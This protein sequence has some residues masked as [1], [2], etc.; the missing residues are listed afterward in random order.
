[1]IQTLHQAHEEIKSY[2]DKKNYALAQD[3]LGQCQECAISIGTLIEKL[4][5]EG[6]ITVSYVEAYCDVVFSAYEELN[7]KDVNTNK[8]Y[9]N[10]KKQLLRIENSLKNDVPVRKEIAFFPYKASMWDALESVYLA[11]K[12][13]PDCDAYCVPIPYYDRNPDRS[14]GQMHYEGREYPKNIEV[15]DWQTYNFEERKP[16]VVYIHNPYDDWNLVTCVHPRF[17]SANL[18]K[19][20]EELVYI[21]YFVLSEIEPDDQAGIDGMKHFCFLPGVVNA[22]KVILQSEKMKQIYVNEYLKAAQAHGL[23]GY[24]LDRKKLE[25]KFLGLGSPK[26]DKVKNTKKED[27]EIPE[28]WLKIIEKPD[29]SWKK[30]IFYNTSIAALLEHNEKMLEKMKWVFRVF[31]ENKDEV[32]LLW[33][34]HP[35][36]KATVS[37]MRPEL[38]VEYEKLVNQY[39]QEGWGIY[40]DSS[41]MDRA[42]VLSDVYYGDAS[43]VVQMFRSCNKKILIQDVDIY[44]ENVSDEPLMFEDL[45]VEE[46]YSWFTCW[47][48][49]SLFKM[50]NKSDKAECVL[51][52]ENEELGE[53][54]LFS[55]IV[56]DK[57]KLYFIP[58]RS[59]A[60]YSYDKENGDVSRFDIEEARLGKIEGYSG[61]NF[62]SAHLYNNKIYMLPYQ[63]KNLLIFDIETETFEYIDI[64]YDEYMKD[65]S[66]Y[67][68]RFIFQS[69]LVEDKI[70]APLAGNSSV[71]CFDLKDNTIKY[72][73]I[74]SENQGFADI[75]Y[76][77]KN[78]IIVPLVGY[79][80]IKWNHKENIV[81][82]KVVIDKK[83]NDK[84][85]FWGSEIYGDH[86]YLFPNEYDRV[87]KWNLKDDR[88]E[89]MKESEELCIEHRNILADC[90]FT[91]CKVIEGTLYVHTGRRNELCKLDENNR[92]W[93]KKKIYMTERTKEEFEE[94]LCKIYKKC[95]KQ[96][97]YENLIFNMN[98]LLQL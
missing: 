34:P 93:E 5:G 31:K 67:G 4:E 73:L 82:K 1:M 8:V 21:P 44:A 10:L 37:S 76:D 57:N 46:E 49:N 75:S 41:D 98:Y 74:E 12:E 88:I 79:E 84:I 62:Y 69:L 14:F 35:L 85:T 28:E 43:S 97:L 7:G 56:C 20:T 63:R 2:I 51:S 89:T 80:I 78:M 40:D 38:W 33:R 54:R 42:V 29:G 66:N 27:L 86:I 94:T 81:I 83:G 59:K 9:K 15:I 96:V 30:I 90:Q 58:L 39:R 92:R 17:F 87:L 24:H 47:N 60:L 70:Y 52:F 13:D 23:G 18:K 16:D 48:Y 68:G 64:Q 95:N 32:A 61:W 19:Y 3:M 72:Y 25:E 36:I 55:K 50:E 6:F 26:F 65:K 71:A 77:G 22:D 11:A 53:E 45:V 91:M